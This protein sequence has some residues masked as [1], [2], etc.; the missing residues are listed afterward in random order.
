MKEDP[1]PGLAVPGLEGVRGRVG[2]GVVVPPP[3]PP[4]K[5]APTVGV[6]PP[7]PVRVMAGENVGQAVGVER[8]D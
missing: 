4:L 3:S 2:R 6:M 8:E 5:V 7:E 1:N